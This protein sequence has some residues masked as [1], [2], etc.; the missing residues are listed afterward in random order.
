MSANI[1]TP[2]GYQ[3]CIHCANIG[4]IGLLPVVLL[5]YIAPIYPLQIFVVVCQKII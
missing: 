5:K 2:A 1:A 4:S 3:Y